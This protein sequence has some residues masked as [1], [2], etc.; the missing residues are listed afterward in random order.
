MK[1]EIVVCRPQKCVLYQLMTKHSKKFQLLFVFGNA[2][3]T[4]TQIAREVNRKLPN[5][6]NDLKTLESLGFVRRFEGYRR[7]VYWEPT[8]DELIIKFSKQDNTLEI[9]G[10]PLV[11]VTYAE[12]KQK[13][14]NRRRCL[15]K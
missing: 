7:T 5:V 10:C 1:C 2:P 9:S 15:K 13:T 8:F 14:L 6:L 3:M 12:P 4:T 11:P